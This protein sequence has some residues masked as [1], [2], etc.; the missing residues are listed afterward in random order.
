MADRTKQRARAS[1]YVLSTAQIALGAAT[2]SALPGPAN[3]QASKS[4]LPCPNSQP[5]TSN[6]V[7]P[8]L[9]QN[10]IPVPPATSAP[11]P[12]SAQGSMQPPLFSGTTQAQQ[13]RL[14]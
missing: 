13:K 14:Q 3:A 7:D 9:D 8:F 1:L 2:L 4:P 11:A 12:A 6:A 5:Q 10:C